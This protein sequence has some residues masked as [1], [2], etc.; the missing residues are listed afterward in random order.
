VSAP[1]HSIIVS[2]SYSPALDQCV[3]ALELLLNKPLAIEGSPV[4]ATLDDAKVRPTS[5]DSRARSRI[6]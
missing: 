2:R 4:L 5:D 6:P 3:R 1:K